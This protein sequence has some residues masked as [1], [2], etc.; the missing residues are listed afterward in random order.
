MTDTLAATQ[1]DLFGPGV[2]TLR[3]VDGLTCLRDVVPEAVEAAIHLADWRP[4]E[5]H[6]NGLSGDWAYTIRR[7]GLRFEYRPD[8]SGV[9]SKLRCITWTELT[10]QIGDD[11]RRAELIAW[12][13]SLTEPAW[14]ERIRPHE[15]WPH[16]GQWHPDYIRNDHE[17]PGWDR[18][19][20]A[21]RTLQAICT[22][23][24]TR[25]NMEGAL[26]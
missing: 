22:D 11:P 16:P 1:L 4:I 2:E 7:A 23:A 17:H 18:R 9:R 20:T 19:L 25:L 13:E 6:G 15:L 14:Q 5:D 10:D 24:I 21:W 12:S 3:L 26:A 8:W